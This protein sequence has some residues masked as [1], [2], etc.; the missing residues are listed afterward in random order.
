M[1]LSVAIYMYIEVESMCIV[2]M[3]IHLY[4]LDIFEKINY[5]EK[6][7]KIKE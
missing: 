1:L 6:K 4:Q 3:H 2:Y 7:K 5:L